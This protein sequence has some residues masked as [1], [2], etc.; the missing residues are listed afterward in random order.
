MIEINLLPDRRKEKDGFMKTFVA[1]V[2][3]W[4]VGLS[5]FGRTSVTSL[6]KPPAKYDSTKR[7]N[8]F[9]CKHFFLEYEGRP[10]STIWYCH[11]CRSPEAK[12]KFQ[13]SC[14]L[15]CRRVN[16]Q[17]QRSPFTLGD[18]KGRNA[19]P[20][21]N[22]FDELEWEEVFIIWPR[23]I[24]GQ[25]TLFETVKTRRTRR[26][27]LIDNG[28]IRLINGREYRHKVS[29]NKSNTL[30]ALGRGEKLK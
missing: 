19:C 6:D 24:N 26:P 25:W 1:P 20:Y 21:Y 2:L 9:N 18:V 13:E 30:N 22:G 29:N 28:G 10:S 27:S 12:K 14:E 17:Y 7:T 11:I 5:D 15:Y 3:S 8:C 4:I 16:S 23:K